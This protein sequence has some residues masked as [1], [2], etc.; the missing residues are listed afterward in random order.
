MWLKIVP[1]TN[2]DHKRKKRSIATNKIWSAMIRK[3]TII[4]ERTLRRRHSLEFRLKFCKPLRPIETDRETEI[5]GSFARKHTSWSSEQ[6]PASSF[7]KNQQGSSLPQDNAMF[8]PQKKNNITIAILLQL[9]NT[10]Q[11][12]W[13]GGYVSKRNSWFVLSLSQH[14]NERIQIS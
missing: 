11:V 2:W 1:G 14:D 7:Q 6:W 12:Y 5:Q 9:S 13:C 8:G 3:G 10:Q 4:N